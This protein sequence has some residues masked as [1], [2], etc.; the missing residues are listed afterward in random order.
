M[1]E[2][3]YSDRMSDSDAV[4]WEIERDPVLRSTITVAWILDGVP[5]RGR[6]DTLVHSIVE[7]I[8]RL[9]QRVVEEPLS[10]IPP[11]WEDDPFF[12]I[13]QHYRWGRLA[14]S[15]P[16][17]RF[18]LDQI[19]LIATRSF[20]KD[21]PLWEMT[22]IEGLPDERCLSILKL[23]HAIADGIGMVQIFSQMADLERDPPARPAVSAP[24][25]A[26][27]G[28]PGGNTLPAVALK[29]M[30]DE[31]QTAARYAKMGVGM[32]R[33]LAKKPVSAAQDA[34]QL[35]GSIFKMVKPAN[36][37]LS[38]LMVGRGLSVRLDTISVPLDGLKAGAKSIGGSL[39]DGFVSAVL[40][41]L[42]K[43][44]RRLGVSAEAIRMNMPIS[45]RGVA[46]G[47]HDSSNQFVPA[48]IV[49]PLGE[50]EPRAR[51]EQAREILRQATTEPALPLLTEISSAIRRLGP[52]ATVS[53]IGSMMKGVDI[54]TSNVPGPPFPLYMAG[55]HIDELFAFGPLSG[56]AI[57]ITLFSYN[58]ALNMAVNTDRIAITHPDLLIECLQ[59]GLDEV[60]ALGVE[61]KPT[62]RS[63]TKRTG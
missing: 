28:I 43:Y 55:Q 44:H 15:S 29:R 35:A 25:L 13:D 6:V 27:G 7:T 51:L 3:E 8:P 49:F 22:M 30:V 39:N 31:S 10:L 9:R 45:I 24:P 60:I 11:R 61:S 50:L 36:S 17:R 46:G 19:S 56:S 5:E 20:D 1:A 58:G 21:R 40:S 37:P 54:T 34:T 16:T 18:G 14:T 47:Q 32:L 26:T 23:H 53:V 63:S 52:S 57:N 38:P 48:R 41:G 2:I 33:T 62:K 12:D 59:A 4:I 42:D